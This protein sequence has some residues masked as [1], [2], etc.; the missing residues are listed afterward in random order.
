MS[1]SGSGG[2][3]AR[4]AP[5][6]LSALRIVATF[7]FM[8]HGTMK[9]FAFPA[10][11]GPAGGTVPLNSLPGFAGLLEV[12]GGTL[13]LLGLFTQ[14]IAFLLSGEMAVAYFKA[15]APGGFWPVLNHGEPAV[16]YCFIF[17]YLAAAG[18]G[19]LS[20]DALGARR[21]NVA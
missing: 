15:H 16:L 17:L 8:S 20:L 1:N 4:F 5:V 21:T 11:M 9:L 6:L 3:L 13:L 14:P 7:I 12:L 18:G 2:P 19:S 10:A